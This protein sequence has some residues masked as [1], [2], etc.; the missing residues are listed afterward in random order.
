MDYFYDIEFK[1][2]VVTVFGVEKD[3]EFILSLKNH[4][5]TLGT[6]A[7]SGDINATL[8]TDYLIIAPDEN[9]NKKFIVHTE[10]V[11]ARSKERGITFG[12]VSVEAQLKDI[13][14][15]VIGADD[16]CAIA[17]MAKGDLVYPLAIAKV[18]KEREKYDM[19]YIDDISKPYRRFTAREISRRI[20]Y[21]AGV[22]IINTDSDYVEQ[23][24]APSQEV[25]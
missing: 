7:V 17:N 5:E 10:E 6:V 20:T 11:I 12:V 22:R 4:L 3:S 16:F 23:L 2:G 18:I 14:D 1:K 25:L 19:L 9:K 24:L 13:E 15:S 8:D 21:G